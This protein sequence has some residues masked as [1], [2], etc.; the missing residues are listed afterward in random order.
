MTNEVCPGTKLMPRIPY[1]D[2][3]KVTDEY[4]DILKGR[5]DLNLYKMLPHAPAIAPKFLRM[6]RAILRESALDPKLREIAILRVNFLSGDSYDLHHH[7]RAGRNVGLSE[8]QIAA[9]MN[10]KDDASWSALEQLVIHYA[11]EVVKNVKAPDRL[12]NE[13]L[14]HLDHQRMAELTLTIGFYMLAG[15]F[16]E[17][18]EVGVE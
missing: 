13:L 5:Y 1:F 18:F 4:R 15:R 10:G 14:G 8:E 17:N 12:F 3:E 2:T 6:G 9:L 7:T 16:L 11:D